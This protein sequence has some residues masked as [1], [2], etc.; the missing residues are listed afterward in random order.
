MNSAHQLL[1]NRI[2]R[3]CLQDGPGIRTTVFTQG[4][5]LRC[6]WC[7]NPDTRPPHDPKAHRWDID[8]LA[9]ELER[10]ARYW[11]R[12]GGG[13]TVSGGECLIQPRPLAA[14]LHEMGRRGHDR[15]VE[16]AGAVPQAH[17]EGVAP[18][19][20]RWLYDI[21]ALSPARYEAG[22][23]GRDADLPVRNLRWLLAH[24]PA[25]VTVRVPLVGGFN[26]GT[27]EPQ[28]IGR[29]VADMARPVQVEILPGHSVGCDLR[30]ENPGPEACRD[31]ILRAEETFHSFQLEVLVRW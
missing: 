6:W 16:T 28:L 21:K 24:T 20:D 4:C 19:V 8:A 29:M 26:A 11:R 27:E 13:V 1:V 2:Q 10:D 31:D 9:R 7:H 23:L 17:F 14:F 18:V 22:T 5:S 12:S 15:C 3:F 25:P 30:D